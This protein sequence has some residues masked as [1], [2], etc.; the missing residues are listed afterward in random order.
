MG[1]RTGEEFLRGL[2][3]SSREVYIE[4]E[5]VRDVTT[6]RA[7]RNVL[8]SL[9]HLYDMQHD[10]EIRDD[11]TYPSPE[12]GD[13]VGTPFMQPRTKD[14]LLKRSR[15]MSHWARF[16]HGMMGRTPDYLSSALMAFAGAKDYFAAT[17][18]RFGDNV[19]R[20]YREAREQ[21][22]CLTH[23]LINPQAN[24]S[25]GPSG[26]ADPFLAARVVKEVDGG[27]IIRGARM[28]A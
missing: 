6:H 20:Y 1:A 27:I 15:A 11:M 24:R 13:P 14:D 19:E 10:S 25:V 18:S 7:F 4:G 16:S 12:S 8:D 26:Q 9:A 28:L 17:D 21:D 5:L 3:E 23:T 2:R 22:L